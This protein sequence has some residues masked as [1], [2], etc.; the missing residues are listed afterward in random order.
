MKSLL[1]FLCGMM[2]V[3]VI[4]AQNI[5]S[6]SPANKNV[7]L[8]EFTGIHCTFC[9]DGHVRANNFSNANPGRV[10][11]INVHTGSYANPS[12][13]EP[14][15]RTSFGSGI[16]GQSGLTGYP[17]GTINRRNFS[18]SGWSQG[19]G[20]AMSRGDW[21]SAGNVIIGESSPVNVA[22]E[23]TIDLQTRNL[24]VINETYYTSSSGVSTNNL[25]VVLLQDNIPGPQ[26]GGSTYNPSAILPNG[27]YN[28]THMLRHMVT[29]QWGTTI[30]TTTSGTFQADTFNYAIPADYN[31]VANNLMDMHVAT[32]VAE[33]QQTILTGANSAMTYQTPPGTS[34][35]DMSISANATAPTGYCSGSY[36]PSISVTNTSSSSI[37]T[38]E[39]SY[40]LNGGAPQTQLITTPLAA[41]ANTTVSF[42][43]ITLSGANNT[44]AYSYDFDTYNST[45]IDG[46][47]SNNSTIDGPYTLF[48][49]TTPHATLS[50]NFQSIGM[51]PNSGGFAYS[52]VIPN[53]VMVNPDD[54]SIGAFGVFQAVA[55]ANP[56]VGKCIRYSFASSSFTANATGS[57]IFEQVDMSNTSA[58]TL[59]F[60]YAHA[61][62]TS[63]AGCMLEVDVSTDC[64]ATWTTVWTRSG[65]TLVNNGLVSGAFYYLGANDYENISVD[66]SA[67]LNNSAVT[68]RFKGTKG[69]SGSGNSLYLDN[70]NLALVSG[71]EQVEAVEE[72]NIMP[73][74]VRDVMTVAFSLEEAKD[75]NINILNA[76]GQQ[77]QQV[78]ASNFVGNNTL[79]VNTNNL[80]A[81]IYFLNITSATGTKTERFVVEK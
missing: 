35:A 31:G 62:L 23:A 40:T 39:V 19:T 17:A 73:N 30:S 56:T 63:N 20:T 74:P 65:T 52:D 24:E 37:D 49:N 14:D 18:G 64:G 11:L 10:V 53:G 6:T 72:L 47:S 32:F 43:A 67:Y 58:A 16:A 59:T 61:Q 26:T 34:I 54:L 71:T 28:H 41:G 42:N 2:A 78:A 33:G 57:I 69:A 60:D 7:V 46:S 68:V 50:E 13:G 76:L 79:T 4:N 15:F 38:F 5:V 51:T 80:A 66:M 81:G 70:I 29:G 25:N 9:P 55:P 36:T 45:L 27:D 22:S 1:L 75:L 21:T 44:I 12:S 48:A 77:V 8:E 3:G